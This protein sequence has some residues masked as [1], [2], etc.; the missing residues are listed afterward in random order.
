MR[1]VPINGGCWGTLERRPP[2]HEEQA[3]YQG[4]C[5]LP[6]AAKSRVPQSV[7]P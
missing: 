5:Y 4:K 6:V 7:K 2:C 1:L 3:E